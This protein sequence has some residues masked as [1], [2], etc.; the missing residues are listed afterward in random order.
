MICPW[1]LSHTLF[2]IQPVSSQRGY[3]WKL[4]SRVPSSQRTSRKLTFAPK[5]SCVSFGALENLIKSVDTP[6]TIKILT[7]KLWTLNRWWELNVMQSQAVRWCHAVSGRQRW[8]GDCQVWCELH[9]FSAF[10]SSCSLFS[11]VE[12]DTSFLWPKLALNLPRSW[13][14][15][16]NPDLFPSR[17]HWDC[18]CLWDLGLM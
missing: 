6:L 7:L 14:C 11:F 1:K 10:K 16:S 5:S 17:N 4:H 13:G 9:T 15:S 2:H 18:G 12:A 3:S 8:S